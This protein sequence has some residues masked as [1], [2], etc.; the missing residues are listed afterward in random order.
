MPKSLKSRLSSDRLT[1]APGVFDMISLRMA[2]AAGCDAAYMTGYGTVASHLGLPDAG[3]ASYRDMVN[4]VEIFGAYCRDHEVPLIAD[5]DTGY[6]GVINVAHTVRGYE[7]AG[8]SAI[9]LED[10]TFPKKCGHTPG[11]EVISVEEMVAKIKVACEVRKND[12]FLIIARTDARTAYG[13]EEAIAR[14]KKYEAAGADI[15]FI[16][17]PE[18]RDEMAAIGKN[19]TKPLLVNLVEGGRTPV[20]PH[21]DL[22]ELGFKLAI[23]PATG[24]LAVGAALENVYANLVDGGSGKVDTPLYDFESF[25]RLMGFEEIWDMEERYRL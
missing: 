4:R 22:E 20:L 3:L 9:Q 6:G 8:A 15:L 1:V 14:M 7:A 25:N 21:G 17:S 12:D 23:Y 11:R 5:G 16:E 13:L 24:F 19:F 10:Q 2:V 18:S